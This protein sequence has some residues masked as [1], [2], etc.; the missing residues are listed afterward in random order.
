MFWKETV[1]SFFRIGAFKKAMVQAERHFQLL[2]GSGC[3]YLNKDIG[4]LKGQD[5]PYFNDVCTSLQHI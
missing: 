1:C 4:P 2:P 3:R 5:S